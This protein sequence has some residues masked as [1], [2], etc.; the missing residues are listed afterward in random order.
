[1]MPGFVVMRHSHAPIEECQNT[2]SMP[3][4]IGLVSMG[5]KQNIVSLSLYY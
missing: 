4:C 1:M 3:M 2:H 5:Q